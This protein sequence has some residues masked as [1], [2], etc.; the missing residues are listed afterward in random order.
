MGTQLVKNIHNSLKS[1]TPILPL[2]LT[3]YQ[4]LFLNLFITINFSCSNFELAFVTCLLFLVVLWRTCGSIQHLAYHTYN[5]CFSC[6]FCVAGL[7]V[8]M[9]PSWC[10]VCSYA[11]IKKPRIHLN[12]QKRTRCMQLQRRVCVCV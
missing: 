12:P 5:F 6:C 10:F 1:I 4:T 7:V 9:L 2:S 3:L 11:N 8:L